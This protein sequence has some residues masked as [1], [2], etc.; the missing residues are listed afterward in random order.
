MIPPF[1]DARLVVVEE[2]LSGDVGTALRWRWSSGG[3]ET[4]PMVGH[5]GGRRSVLLCVVVGRWESR[6]RWLG[7]WM[8]QMERR[9]G[10]VLVAHR[11]LQVCRL[12]KGLLCGGRKT[13]GFQPA[14]KT[15]TLVGVFGS[16][17][18]GAEWGFVLD[19]SDGRLSSFVGGGGRE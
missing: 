16:G 2:Q 6:S 7:S 14:R 8:L 19:V 10:R 3:L 4:W 5:W 1:F 13:G 12:A 18:V 11:R 9:C 17:V 15:V